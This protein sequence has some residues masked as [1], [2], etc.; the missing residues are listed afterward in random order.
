MLGKLTIDALPFYS[1]VAMSGAAVTVLGGL[2]VL[3]L[4]LW[5]GIR[6]VWTEWLTSV[7][8]KRIGIMYIALASVMLLRGFVD[9]IMM[10]SQQ[11]VALNFRVLD[12][13]GNEVYTGTLG[14]E[15]TL[16]AGRYTVAIGGDSSAAIGNVIVGGGPTI[17]ELREQDGKLTG[18]VVKP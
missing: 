15:T 2:I 6:R 3:A 11:A 13:Q 1:W 4:A 18:E 16:P 14:S 8:H 12:E 17:V 9:A 7:D 5:F 10:R